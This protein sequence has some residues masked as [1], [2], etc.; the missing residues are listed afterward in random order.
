MLQQIFEQYLANPSDFVDVSKEGVRCTASDLEN[1]GSGRGREFQ[2]L[3]KEWPAFAVE[4]AGVGLRTVRAHWG[5]ITRRPAEIRPE[6][7]AMLLE[8]Q[9]AVDTLDLC[10]ELI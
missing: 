7:N 6:C 5:P 1:F 9:H 4:F 8:V 3:S 10:P 2:R